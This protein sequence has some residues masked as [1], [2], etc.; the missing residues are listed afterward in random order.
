MTNSRLNLYLAGDSQAVE[1][2]HAAYHDTNSESPIMSSVVAASN[3]IPPSCIKIL[4]VGCAMGVFG[5]FIKKLDPKKHVT[6]IEFV[7]EAA[8]KAKEVLDDVIMVDLDIF[9]SL[10]FPHGFFDCI[11][12]LDV[13]EHLPHP[14]RTLSKLLPYLNHAGVLVCSIPNILHH[15]TISQLLL[16]QRFTNE[17][18]TAWHHLQFWSFEETV[19]LINAL[20]LLIEEPVIGTTSPPSPLLEAIFQLAEL[21]FGPLYPSLQKETHVF[22][23]VFRC[24]KS[25]DPLPI[26]RNFSPEMQLIP[27]SVIKVEH[28]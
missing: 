6:G 4:D 16:A 23:Y 5:K 19:E 3:L 13:V 24:S 10:P 28:C 27:N 20:G 22:Q 12:A 8:K 9:D 21:H 26:Q 17:A 2:Q 7:P 15:T 14:T 25:S 11:T 1:T 18:A